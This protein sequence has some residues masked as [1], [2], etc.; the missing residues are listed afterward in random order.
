LVEL[1]HTPITIASFTIQ[2]DF[3]FGYINADVFYPALHTIS[4]RELRDQIGIILLVV[5]KNQRML[6][7]GL[8]AK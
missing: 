5:Q 7:Y 4:G 6:E 8:S 3:E 2:H 1:N